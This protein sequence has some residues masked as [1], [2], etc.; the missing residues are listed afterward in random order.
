MANQLISDTISTTCKFIDTAFEMPV[1][2]E[3]LLADYDKAIFKIVKTNVEHSI[4]QKYINGSK[5]VLEGYLKINIYYQP[6]EGGNLTVSRC[7]CP[8]P[9]AFHG[10]LIGLWAVRRPRA[11]S[12]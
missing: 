2:Q 7:P 1:E 9:P 6:P 3:F 12:T 4:T 11:M 10:R 5:L 8:V